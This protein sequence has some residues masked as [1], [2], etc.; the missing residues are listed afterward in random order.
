MGSRYEWVEDREDHPLIDQAQ[1]Y[2][3]L[4]SCNQDYAD[5]EH[6]YKRLQT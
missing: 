2:G 1:T 4:R 5:S 6:A 3:I